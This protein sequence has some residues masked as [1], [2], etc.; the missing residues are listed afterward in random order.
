MCS[1]SNL[2]NRLFVIYYIEI[3]N[4]TK[5]YREI[6]MTYLQQKTIDEMMRQGLHTQ[7]NTAEQCWKKNIEYKLQGNIHIPKLLNNLIE[8]SNREIEKVIH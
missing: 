1:I 8:K 3:V 2:S 4:L 6:I 7:L 5:I